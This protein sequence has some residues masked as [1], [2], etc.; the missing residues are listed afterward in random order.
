M[1]QQSKTALCSQML[2]KALHRG[3]SFENEWMSSV[4][5]RRGAV[6]NIFQSRGKTTRQYCEPKRYIL[7]EESGEKHAVTERRSHHGF[8]EEQKRINLTWIPD[9]MPHKW[10]LKSILDNVQRETN[11]S[12]P[13][14]WWINK[15]KVW[16]SNLRKKNVTSAFQKYD[17][18]VLW[19][20]F[21]L[22]LHSTCYK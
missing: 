3:L 20:F 21:S 15:M 19:F 18:H 9:T 14:I 16:D 6:G 11:L 2:N 12:V 13:T 22:H 1:G 5:H 7:R 10:S 4:F 17:L 8:L